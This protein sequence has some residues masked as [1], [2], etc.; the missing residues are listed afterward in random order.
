MRIFLALIGIAFCFDVSAQ[1]LP[2]KEQFYQQEI[3]AC[4]QGKA[5]A[6]GKLLDEIERLKAELKK[7]EEKK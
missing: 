2:T 7:Q 3:A 6:V 4:A 1:E 5:I